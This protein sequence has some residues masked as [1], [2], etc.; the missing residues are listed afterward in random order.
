MDQKQR[1]QNKTL[2]KRNKK[3]SYFTLFMVKLSYRQLYGKNV[4][5]K[6]ATAKIM[7]TTEDNLGHSLG[8][9][10]V[11]RAEGSKS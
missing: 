11:S 4:C 1:K 8:R 7:D 6:D 3:V 9:S 2:L 10:S 5:S